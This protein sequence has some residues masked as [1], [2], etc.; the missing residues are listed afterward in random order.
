[1]VRRESRD[2]DY[3][4]LYRFNRNNIEWLAQHFL[5]HEFES[6]SDALT[7]TERMRIFLRY[8]VDPRFQS[9]VDLQTELFEVLI[10]R[11]AGRT[12]LENTLNKTCKR[13]YK[14][15]QNCLK[16]IICSAV[17]HPSCAKH[18]K[19]IKFIDEKQVICC[20]N[21]ANTN[22][23]DEDENSNKRDLNDPIC[24]YLIEIKYLKELVTEKN[25]AINTQQIAIDSLQNQIALLNKLQCSEIPKVDNSASSKLSNAKSVTAKKSTIQNKSQY[26]NIIDGKPNEK[27]GLKNTSIQQKNNYADNKSLTSWIPGMPSITISSETPFDLSVGA[28]NICLSAVS[29]KIEQPKYRGASRAGY[30]A[31]GRGAVRPHGTGPAVKGWVD[32]PPGP[33]LM[34]GDNGI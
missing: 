26:K 11:L 27:D 34:A 15:P 14:I 30:A 10:W 21:T 33:D 29:F 7:T 5:E 28:S 31:A 4:I 17:Y 18:T 32:F 6:R 19:L 24:L 2:I 8:A 25:T 3:L 23:H 22:R 16:C 13:C 1:M 12:L 20:E 9:D